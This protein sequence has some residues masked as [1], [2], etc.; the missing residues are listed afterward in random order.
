MIDEGEFSK[1]RDE[2][3]QQDEVREQLIK[4]SR[5]ILKASKQAIYSLH[6]SDVENAEKLLSEAEKVA[7]E[8]T[9][10]LKKQ[11]ELR[12]QGAFTAGL[13]EY[14]EAK[15]FLHFLSTGK[16]VKLSE[17]K[18]ISG[19]E[20]VR[21]LSDLTGELMRYAVLRA[22]AGDHEMVQKIRDLID[23]IF[24]QL[25]QFDFRNSDARRKYDAIKYNLQKVESL[26]Y[27]LS[28]KSS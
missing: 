15:G 12:M 2:F 17:L 27:D 6:R 16:L 7:A 22:T 1:I 20:Y 3:S 14:V 8:L 25:A 21:G 28:L 4:R 26:L 23:A 24:G 11:P 9:K 10:L 19:D 5:E 13:E 18:G